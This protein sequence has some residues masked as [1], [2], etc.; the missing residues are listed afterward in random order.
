LYSDLVSDV[1]SKLP[2]S[3]RMTRFALSHDIELMF[4]DL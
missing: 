2:V 3:S 1:S 4:I